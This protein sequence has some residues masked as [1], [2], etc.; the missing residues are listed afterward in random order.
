MGDRELRVKLH[1]LKDAGKDAFVIDPVAKW[2]GFGVVDAGRAIEVRL[3]DIALQRLDRTS[4]GANHTRVL[5]AHR[6]EIFKI[7][8]EKYEDGLIEPGD[9]ISITDADVA[10]LLR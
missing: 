8:A 2:I 6:S 7:A 10:Q 3:E 1:K 5:D 4:C 9:I